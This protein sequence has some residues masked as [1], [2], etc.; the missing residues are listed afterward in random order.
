MIFLCTFGVH[1]NFIIIYILSLSVGEIKTKKINF[2]CRLRPTI[3]FMVIWMRDQ[4]VFTVH[5]FTFVFF[6]TLMVSMSVCH[7]V[8]NKRACLL[9]YLLTY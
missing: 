8:T 4:A 1:V 5:D 7:M 9:T 2:T 6:C 3:Y